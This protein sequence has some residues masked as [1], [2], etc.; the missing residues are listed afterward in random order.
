MGPLSWRTKLVAGLT[1]LVVGPLVLLRA[2]GIADNR[3]LLLALLLSPAVIVIVLRLTGPVHELSVIAWRLKS[4]DLAARPAVKLEQPWQQVAAS[5]LHLAEQL[6]TVSTDL[7][8]QVAE[9][10]AELA[11]KASQLRALG[12][13]GHQVAAV[14]EPKQLL[15]F[16]VRLVRGTFGYDVVAVIQRTKGHFIVSA[17]A[18]KGSTEPPT[19]RLFRPD[20]PH[21]AAVAR[22]FHCESRTQDT[23]RQV[24]GAEEVFDAGPIPLVDS[25]KAK[26]EL[27][28]PVELAARVLGVMVVQRTSGEPFDDDDVFTVKTIAGQVAVALE[29]ARLFDTERQLRQMA[30]TEERH[31]MSRE[32]HDTLAQG[33]MG[34]LMHL[35][36]MR[37]V[38]DETKAKE[39]R[40]AAETL[41]QQSLDEARRSVW[42]LRP[43]RLHGQGLSDALR[44][45]VKRLESQASLTAVLQLPKD[46]KTVDNL[47][48]DHAATL[49]RIAQEALH[50][51]AK[52]AQAT[53]VFVTVYAD[54]EKAMLQV[55]DDGIGFALHR[56][57]TEDAGP[58][59]EATA[60]VDAS[61]RERKGEHPRTRRPTYGVV[62][63]HER[64]RRLGGTVQIDSSPGQ[65]TT[66]R[67]HL[68]LRKE[69]VQ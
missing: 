33:F 45:E 59:N 6:H 67:V 40:A 17:C 1:A 10:T 14:L 50:N 24:G 54:D 64:A 32:I 48:G 9:R 60:E 3:A 66:V 41:A 39:H 5:L 25:I 57:E 62:G 51:V 58:K 7:E 46:V 29:N 23:D 38:D 27:L 8:R 34:I 65:G 15:H 69:A 12:Q 30:I 68:P 56:S 13:V 11:R 28:T 20:D 63:M 47:P 2:L 42:N 18:A 55:K 36:A 22:F 31:R 61:K 16:V 44:D 52:H 26:S 53:N 35:R 49:L 4:G 19:G 21:I 43:A 37:V